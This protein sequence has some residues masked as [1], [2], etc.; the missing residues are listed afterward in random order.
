[1]ATNRT[2]TE[3]EKK[4]LQAQHRM[5]AIEARNRQKERKARTR[6]LI[7]MGAVL[8]SVFP[9]VQTMELDDVKM[10]LKRRLNVKAEIKAK[11]AEKKELIAEQKNCGIH[12]IRASRLGEQIAKL[13]EDIEEL[14]FQKAQLLSRLNCQDNGIAS[15][16][17]KV[18]E[19]DTF[20][21]KLEQKHITLSEQKE[22]DKQKF[23]EIRNGIAPENQDAVMAER[24]AIRP[25][26]KV[27]LIQKLYAVYKDKY[28]S[29]IF[30][31][32]NRQI[33]AELQ[34]KPIIKRKR[35]I[36]EQLKSPRQEISQP[37]KKKKEYER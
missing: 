24:E 28:R 36:S 8:E 7:Q 27:E 5:E 1:M 29:D 11:T 3:N 19:M 18:K 31:E 33:D 12:F 17:K 22:S 32:A 21:G 4:L 10:E 13:T 20:L 37:P 6:R 2:M 15:Q 26:A 30:D 34:E 25:D 14:K 35:S 16:D 9:E 23:L